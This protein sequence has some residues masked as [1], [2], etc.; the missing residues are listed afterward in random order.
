[1]KKIKL[2]LKLTLLI[3]LINLPIGIIGTFLD[4]RDFSIYIIL[5]SVFLVDSIFLV[6]LIRYIK[7][8]YIELFLLLLIFLSLIIGLINN[9]FSRSFIVDFINPIYFIL[10]IALFRN[11][12]SKDEVIKF[13]KENISLASKYLFIFSFLTIILFYIFST[14]DNLYVGNGLT[15]HPF[16][17]LS[18]LSGSIYQTILVFFIVI[19]SGKRALLLSSIFLI[20]F[21]QVKI[22]KKIPYKFL[23]IITVFSFSFYSY[24]SADLDEYLSLGKYIWTY[25]KLV[26]S[27]FDFNLDNELI[28]LASAGRLGEINAAVNK[29][30]F[31]DFIIG[32]G[33]GYKYDYIDLYGEIVQNYNNLH[34]TP[35]GLILKYGFLYFIFL[36]Y[37]ILKNLK[38]IANYGY[39]NIFFGLYLIALLVDMMFA[40]SI[41][42]DP[43]LPIALGYLS[44]PK[45]IK[46]SYNLKN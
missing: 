3:S 10:K 36:F 23:I 26:E 39:L 2:Y 37:Y 27:E 38:N 13:V 22:V 25:D 24:F 46:N 16:L 29:M 35:I 15:T 44:I 42:I 21:S 4:F 11:F 30:N 7:I 45:K 18:I 14:I 6:S 33:V 28:N 12:F 41:F 34:F 31:F 40:F 9:D 32:K 19:I 5:S 17:I 8:K 20:I 43:F 1:M